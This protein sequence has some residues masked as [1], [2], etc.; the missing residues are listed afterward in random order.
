MDQNKEE[1]LLSPSGQA[2]HVR[3]TTELTQ[4]T[5]HKFAE[6]IR[7]MSNASAKYRSHLERRSWDH[8]LLGDIAS[9]AQ[10]TGKKK[11]A[12]RHIL[13]TDAVFRKVRT[14]ISRDVAYRNLQ[15]HE[16]KHSPLHYPEHLN[17]IRK[18]Y[19]IESHR[20]AARIRAVHEGCT[21]IYGLDVA[22]LRADRGEF[23]DAAVVWI[24]TAQEQ[25]GH[26]LR[27][28][29]VSVRTVWLSEFS[30]I[31]HKGLGDGIDAK[32]SFAGEVGLL[33]GIDC[34]FISDSMT[35]PIRIDVTPPA[36]AF[37]RTIAESERY[38]LRLGRVMNAS[39]G[40]VVSPN[41]SNILWNGN[42]EGAWHVRALSSDAELADVALHLWIAQ[43]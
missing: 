20:L 19:S 38:P 5:S 40:N 25:L 34:E 12:D 15:E 18:Q 26:R 8:T 1:G 22:P 32:F 11:T 6:H 39:P 14:S 16:R 29:R 10:M 23:F 21:K 33:R 4:E 2:E 43:S 17:T 24:A 42:P 28:E 41:F 27:N 31:V 3:V 37:A 9:E 7:N 35:K 30:Q 13:R 36:G